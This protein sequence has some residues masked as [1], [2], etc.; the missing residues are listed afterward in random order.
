ML[1]GKGGHE[2]KGTES[3]PAEF[4]NFPPDQNPDPESKFCVNPVR[5]GFTCQQTFPTVVCNEAER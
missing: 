3:T 4:C 5:P 2:S 1:G